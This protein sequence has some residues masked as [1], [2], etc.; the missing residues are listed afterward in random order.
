M[1]FFFLS[2]K[3][4][5]NDIDDN[6]INVVSNIDSESTDS[7]S[8]ITLS[9]EINDFIW[10]GL[11][12]Y[13]YWQSDVANLADSKATMESE[14]IALL[15]SQQDSK[16]FFEGLLHQDDRFSWIEEDYEVLENQLSGTTASNGM[17]FQLYVRD[18]GQS[19]I[20]AVTYV[21]PESDAFIKGINVE[22]FLIV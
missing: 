1:L 9:T 13:Y 22:I 16:E 11:N 8:E 14:Y 18:D 10:K 3:C 12:Q 2:I 5:K 21:L 17:K 20:G 7:P 15:N 6:E 4:S 19:I